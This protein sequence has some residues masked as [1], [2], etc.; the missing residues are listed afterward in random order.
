[1]LFQS[2]IGGML[3]G[4]IV[5]IHLPP[6]WLSVCTARLPTSHSCST[7]LQKERQASGTPSSVCRSCTLSRPAGK[8]ERLTDIQ[9]VAMR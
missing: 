3:P 7:S 8:T 6:L 9:L 4:N 5:G 1:M 2:V